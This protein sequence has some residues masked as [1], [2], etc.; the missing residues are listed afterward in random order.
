MTKRIVI[1]DD[2]A[3]HRLLYKHRLQSFSGV[4]IVGEFEKAEEA[5]DNIPLLKPNVVIT[6]FTLPGMSGI[7][8]AERLKQYPEIKVFLVSN[9]APEYFSSV[10]KTPVICEIIQKDWSKG[11]FDRILGFCR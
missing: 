11:A 2:D 10:L 5:L 8:V 4:E 7:D 6:D 1:I 3:T 9:H